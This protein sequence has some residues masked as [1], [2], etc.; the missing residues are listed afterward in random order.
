MPK[1]LITG[2]NGFIGRYMLK[3]CKSKGIDVVGTGSMPKQICTDSETKCENYFQM[4]VLDLPSVKKIFNEVNPEWVFH[5]AGAT[6]H[7]E[8]T[9]NR[10]N[11]LQINLIGTMNVLESFNSNNKCKKFIFPS[12]GKVFTPTNDGILADEAP[13][14]SKTILGKNKLIV[15]KIIDFFSTDFSRSYIICRI[16]N[17]YGPGQKIQFLIPTIIN[18]LKSGVIEL[19]N[20][21]DKRDYIFVEDC[22]EG[23]YVAANN[24]SIPGVH[25]LNVGSGTSRSVS[26][27]LEDLAKIIDHPFDIKINKEKIRKGEPPVEQARTEI[28]SSLGWTPKIK[29]YDGLKRC[30]YENY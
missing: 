24:I 10:I 19:G 11:G 4:N 14:E 30:I 28:L 26:M 6:T 18:Q 17:V 20:L 21:T 3:L 27:I 1:V 7:S 8:I 16:F 5:F 12:S 15:E 25:K 13:S 23:L 29:F 22:V 2:V 9:I